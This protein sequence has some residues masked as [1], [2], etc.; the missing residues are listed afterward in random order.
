MESYKNLSHKEKAKRNIFCAI[1]GLAFLLSL[2]ILEKLT[3]EYFILLTFATISV[4]CASIYN[5][6]KSKEE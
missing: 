2:W 4:V 3:I 1:F 5:F 6:K